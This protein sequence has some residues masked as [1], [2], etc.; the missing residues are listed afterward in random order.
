MKRYSVYHDMELYRK[1]R[2][3]MSEE[4]IRNI[5]SLLSGKGNIA[6]SAMRK[7]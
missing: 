7:K 4:K 5:R 6:L 3:D 1:G 2:I